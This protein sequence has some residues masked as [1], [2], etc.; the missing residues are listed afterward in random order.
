MKLFGV[1][2]LSLLLIYPIGVAAEA[3]EKL[4]LRMTLPPIMGSLP[5]VLGHEWGIFH[6]HG[7]DLQLKGLADREGRIAALR[8][9]RIDGM[10]TDLTTA[11]LAALDGIDIVI[12]STAFL[13]QNGAGLALLTQYRTGI[14]SIEDILG[15]FAAGDE[16]ARIHLSHLSN[17]HF[18]TDRLLSQLGFDVYNAANYQ[19][20]TDMVALA[21]SFAFMPRWVP[22]VVLPEPYISFLVHFIP[23]GI[24]GAEIIVLADFLDI[25]PVPSVIIF[26]REFVRQNNEVLRRFHAAHQQ[27]ITR[28]N[29]TSIGELLDLGVDVVVEMFFPGLDPGD[30][31]EIPP[32]VIVQLTIPYFVAPTL[33]APASLAAVMDWLIR[34]GHTRERITYDEIITDLFVR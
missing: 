22:A 15:D 18:Q 14:T 16:R 6:D 29:A 10:V 20:W 1:M 28:L 24:R 19:F 32:E 12:T 9:G 17:L 7:L 33:P 8:A 2:L 5:L 4:Q 34:A 21:R 31:R 13:S 11:I 3:E 27:A 30:P 25:E 26:R 23:L